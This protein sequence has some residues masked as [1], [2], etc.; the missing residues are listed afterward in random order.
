[1]KLCG[2]TERIYCRLRLDQ[3]IIGLRAQDDEPESAFAQDIARRADE[4]GRL[5]A[6]RDAPARQ[7]KL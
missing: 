1:M 6:L 7:S 5:A 3:R 2:E 4:A